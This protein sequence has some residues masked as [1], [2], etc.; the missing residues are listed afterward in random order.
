MVA[1]IFKP[2]HGG[3]LL[4]RLCSMIY[5][6]NY[7]GPRS[8]RKPRVKRFRTES[9]Y[10]IP[11]I[12]HQ[13][14]AILEEINQAQIEHNDE[15]DT[16]DWIDYFTENDDCT[17]VGEELLVFGEWRIGELADRQLK[18][19][20]SVNR[21]FNWRIVIRNSKFEIN[22]IQFTVQVRNTKYE[23][24]RLQQHL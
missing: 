21:H 10:I 4:Q 14:S 22:S 2:L 15:F 1:K 23:I 6:G 7:L 20:M 17:Y 18:W 9:N 12:R 13:D 19:R 8:K 5:E 16:Q 11:K 24:I 3:V